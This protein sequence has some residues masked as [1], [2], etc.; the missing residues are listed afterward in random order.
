MPNAISK[1]KLTHILISNNSNKA[2][3][4]KKGALVAHLV[5]NNPDNQK[6]K[7]RTRF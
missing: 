4:L 7:K 6:S 1:D 2:V 5:A 3:E